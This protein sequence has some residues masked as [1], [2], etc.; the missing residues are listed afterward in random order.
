MT[1]E[2]VEIGDASRQ[3]SFARAPGQ[4]GQA[5]RT[6]DPN[7]HF[8]WGFDLDSFKGHLVNKS[9]GNSPSSIDIKIH[10]GGAPKNQTLKAPQVGSAEVDALIKACQQVWPGFLNSR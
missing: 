9:A 10:T 3:V 5:V 4:V 2:Y 1:I 8:E 7:S 6:I